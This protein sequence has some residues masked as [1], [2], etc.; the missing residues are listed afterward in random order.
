MDRVKKELIET[1]FY[2]HET[3]KADIYMDSI[4]TSTN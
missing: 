4:K 1:I 2:F 3:G